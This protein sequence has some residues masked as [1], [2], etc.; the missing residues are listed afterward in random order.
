MLIIKYKYKKYTNSNIKQVKCIS[1]DKITNSKKC[2]LFVE[3]VKCSENVLHFLIRTSRNY[4]I[5]QHT[6]KTFLH[7]APFHT[8]MR[9][10][11]NSKNYNMR[12]LEHGHSF[13]WPSLIYTSDD[14]QYNNTCL[15]F[16]VGISFSSLD[17]N[18]HTRI[19]SVESYLGPNS[20][21]KT[22]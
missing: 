14:V 3:C 1:T 8:D 15:R 22:F 20:S 17:R 7:S 13:K 16:G 21:G 19:C 5:R 2:Q 4:S 6:V 18:S 9:V 10:L 11:E 12:V